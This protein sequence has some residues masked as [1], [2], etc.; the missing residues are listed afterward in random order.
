MKPY[1]DDG[2]IQLF[3]GDCREAAEW[4]SADVLVTDPPFGMKYSSGWQARP[5]A[6][7][8]DTAARDEALR[9]WGDKPALVFGRWDCPRPA[10]AKLLLTWDKGDWP[11]MGDLALPWGPSTEEIYVLGGGFIGA[12]GGSVVRCDRLTGQTLH[13]NEKPVKLLQRLLGWCEPAAVVADPFS[14]SGAT[15]V[16]AKNLGRRAIGVEL[17][18]RYCEIAAKRL[19]QGVLFSEAS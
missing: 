11:G 10:R 3:H 6:G 16:A 2:K 14:G 9:L 17:E 13:P 4:L 19:S 7:D 12:R 8:D 5:I 18:E 1:F 15:L